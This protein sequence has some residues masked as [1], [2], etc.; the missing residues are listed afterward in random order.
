MF[1]FRKKD[2]DDR[3]RI[4]RALRRP[5]EPDYVRAALKWRLLDDPWRSWLRRSDAGVDLFNRWHE[6]GEHVALLGEAA[7][8]EQLV[9][10]LSR[11]VPRDC[12]AARFG[13]TRRMDRACRNPE[14]CAQDPL[15]GTGAAVHRE[16]PVPGGCDHYVGWWGDSYGLRVAF[17]AGDR[18]RA[19][20]WDRKLWIDGAPIAAEQS[21]DEYGAWLDE[22]FFVILA[23]GPDDHPDQAYI[24]DSPVSA[25]R[26]LVVHDADRAATLVLVPTAGERWTNPTVVRDGDVLLVHPDRDGGAADRTLP[27]Y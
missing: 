20:Q 21:L 24:W 11:A 3:T 4:D 25:I 1:R 5:R 17:S 7:Y 10:T 13:C 27:V 15:P 22:R 2:A 9:R 8:R 16:G 6:A 18:H 23:E 26:S 19:V 12:A 14:I